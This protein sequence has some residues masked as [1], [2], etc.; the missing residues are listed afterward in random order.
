[1]KTYFITFGDMAEALADLRENDARGLF[2]DF[3][4]EEIR[5]HAL[6]LK[7]CRKDKKTIEGKK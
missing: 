4:E 7:R 2:G 5:N 6:E 3:S 1:M